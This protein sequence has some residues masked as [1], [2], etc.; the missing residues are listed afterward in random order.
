MIAS[1]NMVLITFQDGAD[2]KQL[3]TDL[4]DKSE[5]N[6]HNETE[7]MNIEE[8]R[9][10]LAD[11]R[12]HLRCIWVILIVFAVTLLL[13]ACASGNPIQTALA[14][15]DSLPATAR[16]HVAYLYI[17]GEPQSAVLTS[18]Q[19]LVASL[20]RT[21]PLSRQRLTPVGSGLYRLDLAGLQWSPHYQREVRD[22]YPY[23]LFP[24]EKWPL[25]V[26]G[27]W[28]VRHF[29]DFSR[30]AAYYLLTFGKVP[31]TADEFH[32]FVGTQQKSQFSYG[33]IEDSSGVALQST[34]L[35]GVD[36]TDR[37]TSTFQTY[38]FEKIT[39]QNDPLA[40]LTAFQRDIVHDASEIIS[41]LPK[42]WPTGTGALQVYALANGAGQIQKVAPINIVADGTN[43]NG[44]PELR[45]ATSC[46]SC[47]IEGLRPF[48]VNGLKR[49]IESNAELFAA[50]EDLTEIERF[51]LSPLG[52]IVARAN[53]DVAAATREV[54]GL[55]PEEN[56]IRYRGV[57]TKYDDELTLEQ[58]AKELDTS[59]RELALAVAGISVTSIPPRV[60]GLAH[61][62]PISRA[63]FEEH[64]TLLRVAVDQWKEKNVPG[65]SNDGGG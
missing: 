48:S 1:S 44:G 19:Y 23:D 47:H 29:S 17:P 51:Y 59:P 65:N 55:T 12:R 11:I 54:N 15:K 22:R 50:Y 16:A 58:A 43:V 10:E 63:S 46:I 39:L 13:V 4:Q 5:R 57:V 34:R 20:S 62:V 21:V 18:A 32:G 30:S 45:C 37:R 8:L 61:N 42:S 53:E 24:P 9:E 6:S 36:P 25:V 38:D 52:K 26:R 2:N 33:F 56:A 49:Y 14:D 60:A 27:D 40:N 28:F 31:E 64:Y 3:K 7:L 35:I 41:Y